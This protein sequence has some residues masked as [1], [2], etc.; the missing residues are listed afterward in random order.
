MSK[1]LIELT[2]RELSAL[3]A[4]LDAGLSIAPIIKKGDP[5]FAPI[6]RVDDKVLKAMSVMYTR[7]KQQ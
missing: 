7:G 5:D 6:C 4:F 1:N 2:D 3:H